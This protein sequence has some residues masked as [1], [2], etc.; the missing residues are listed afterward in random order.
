[1]ILMNFKIFCGRKNSEV[2]VSINCDLQSHYPHYGNMQVILLK[3]KMG[4]TSRLFKYLWPQKLTLIY[5]G[6]CIGIHASC[7]IT[8]C[9]VHPSIPKKLCSR[10]LS[11]A[12]RGW[13]ILVAP[14]FCPASRVRHRVFLWAQ[15]IKNCWSIF[16]QILT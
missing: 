7:F 3:F 9:E 4:T 10:F 15:K 11:P 1:M 16:F 5:G 2:K 14:G 6:G 8:S 13:G 12:R